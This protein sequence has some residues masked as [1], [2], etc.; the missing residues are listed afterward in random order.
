MLLKI[1]VSVERLFSE[2]EVLMRACSG[3]GEYE[4]GK[5]TITVY[6]LQ[7]TRLHHCNE[8][9]SATQQYYNGEEFLLIFMTSPSPLKD[10]HTTSPGPY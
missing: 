9:I 4:A 2:Y 8:V 1:K 6:S 5:E 10:F 3:T 7:K